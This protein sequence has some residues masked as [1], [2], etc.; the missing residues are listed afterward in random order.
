[1]TNIPEIN[2]KDFNYHLPRERIA[3][4]PLEYRDASKLLICSDNTITED[5][6]SNV[7]HYIH[8]Q[9]LLVFNDTKV[10]RARLIFSKKTGAT[11][12]IF[13]LDPL[14]PTREVS[15]EFQ[16]TTGCTWKCL[17]GNVKR[18]KGELLEKEFIHMGGKYLLFAQRK[19]YLGDG[20]YAVA[21]HW[22]PKNKPF[23]EL[24]EYAG[25]VP[26]PPYITRASGDLDVLRYQTIYAQNEGSV[27][28]PTAGLHFTEKIL[29]TLKQKRC[30][31]E[32]ITLHVGVGTFRP[33]SSPDISKHIMH[34][35]KIH[36][37]KKTIISILNNLGKPLI[38]I[39][40]TSV[41]TLESLYWSGVRLLIDG[42]EIHPEAGQW[43]PYLDRYDQNIS[44]R[45]ALT[46]LVEYLD[47]KKLTSYSGSTQL[48]IIPGYKFR[49]ADGML[50]NFHMPQS[51]LL[52]L[53]AAFI[54]E[55]WRNAYDFAY[56]HDF[57][58]LSYGDACLFFNAGNKITD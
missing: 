41:R 40:T 17:I 47:S 4:F 50:T 39:G 38:A 52:M 31:F 54:G 23:L 42:A 20:C 55:T 25:L 3:Q 58:F 11:I 1:M 10:I 16:Q 2:L 22:E 35:E 33:V 24:L 45:K 12:E 46:T 34:G 48:M 8:W 53:V 28:A 44:V 51:S 21:F 56:Q 57:R 43:D 19:E 15:D 7:A 6:F 37:N 5:I 36:V 32:N 14:A 26:L 13:C 30:L 29:S 18:W 27:A 9:S 49:F